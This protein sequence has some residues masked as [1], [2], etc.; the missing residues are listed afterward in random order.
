MDKTGLCHGQF[1][2]IF[3]RG[4]NWEPIFKEERNYYYFLELYKRYLHPI[5]DLYAYC[6]L[7]THMHFLIMIKDLDR[8]DEM[9][10]EPSSLWMQLRNFL[11]TYTRVMN[12]EYHRRGHL[13]EG[14]CST[15]GARGEDYLLNLIAYIHQCPQ[16]HGV[17]SEYRFWPFSSY[18]AYQRR[19]RRSLLARVLFADD[20]LYFSILEKHQQDPYLLEACIN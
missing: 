13:L 9:H 7:P 20:Q 11:G 2:H 3:F 8:I 18:N 6:L 1:Y 12:R 4:N 10:Y 16:S 19:D 17:V 15:V 14:R 5:A